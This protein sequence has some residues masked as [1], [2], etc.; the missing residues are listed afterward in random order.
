MNAMRRGARLFPVGILKV[1]GNFDYGDLV[2]IES[3]GRDAFISI[4]EANS[5]YLRDNKGKRTDVI[6][7]LT[8]TTQIPVVSRKKYRYRNGNTANS[9]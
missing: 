4:V 3:I 6:M 5:K 2:Q 9:L 1:S 8:Q 7:E